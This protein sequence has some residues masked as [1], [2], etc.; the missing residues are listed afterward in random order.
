MSGLSLD[1]T[2]GQGTPHQAPA[3]I[4]YFTLPLAIVTVAGLPQRGDLGDRGQEGRPQAGDLELHD[5]ALPCRHSPPA[6]VL[7]RTP[8]LA[9]GAGRV[10]AGHAGQ[11][12]V[13]VG[14]DPVRP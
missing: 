8:S 6:Q 1:E 11:G 12:P 5:S 10:L 4:V 14:T 7:E 3:V 9:L 13:K 2:P